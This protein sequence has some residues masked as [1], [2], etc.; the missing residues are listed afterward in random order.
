M[1]KFLLALVALF[2]TL[3]IS[4]QSYNIVITTSTGTQIALPAN[5]IGSISF[6]NGKLV[7]DGTDLSK[8]TTSKSLDSLNQKYED[9]FQE[10]YAMLQYSRELLSKSMDDL[11]GNLKDSV[12]ALRQNIAN[13]RTSLNP[14][15]TDY[16]QLWNEINYIKSWN[17]KL[18]STIN[19]VEKN[20]EDRDDVLESQV[21]DIFTAITS[22]QNDVQQNVTREVSMQEMIN[23]LNTNISFLYGK[24]NEI[25]NR[26]S[27]LEATT[28]RAKQK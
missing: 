12:K 15:S 26:L 27:T 20:A 17:D 7:I 25:D 18:L 4:A 23:T 14:D 5:E 11:D 21:K 8:I 24:I 10:V 13:I 19:L 22:L 3:T 6:N 16:S 9:R 2:I 28:G 1:K